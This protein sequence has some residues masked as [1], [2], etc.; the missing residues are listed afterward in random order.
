[1]TLKGEPVG[2]LR[3]RV[4]DWRLLYQVDDGHLTVL[5]VDLGHRFSIYRR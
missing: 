5:V 3:V 2:V 4:G 1:M